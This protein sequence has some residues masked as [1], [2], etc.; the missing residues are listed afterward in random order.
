[1]LEGRPSGRISVYQSASKTTRAKGLECHTEEFGTQS[2]LAKLLPL[3]F[4]SPGMAPQ[5]AHY[6]Q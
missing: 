3:P 2:P 4:L 1:M 6:I 5:A